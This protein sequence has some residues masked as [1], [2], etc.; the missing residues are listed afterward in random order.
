MR[1]NVV[2]LREVQGNDQVVGAIGGLF[3]L[4]LVPT[5][6]YGDLHLILEIRKLNLL[7]WLISM[8][9]GWWIGGFSGPWARRRFGTERSEIIGGVCGGLVPVVLVAALGWYIHV[10]FAQ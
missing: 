2:N 3:A 8:A 5:I 1:S 7:S 4:G 6:L 9:A 10:R